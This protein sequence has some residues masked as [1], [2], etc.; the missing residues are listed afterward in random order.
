MILAS[1]SRSRAALLRGAGVT[2]DAVP[3]DV[4]EDAVKAELREPRVVAE[5]LAELKALKISA[6]HPGIL[7]LGADQVLDLDGVAMSKAATREIAAAQLRAMRGKS[8]RLISALALTRGGRVV[9]RHVD[10]ATL[11]VRDFSEAFLEAYL[12]AE[13]GEI[14]GSV[15]CYRLE[16]MGA[17]LFERIEGDYFSI[18][19]LPLLPL[20]GALREMGEVAT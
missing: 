19:G 4:D 1:A 17:Q 5:T 13:S 20:L 2:F 14:L 12:D 16:G 15:G 3:A 9:W 10:I 6:S 18:L 11:W 7:V 8:H